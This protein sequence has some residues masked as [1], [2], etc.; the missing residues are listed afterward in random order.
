M[1][2]LPEFCREPKFH[3]N[4]EWIAGHGS[5]EESI[6]DPA[7]GSVVARYRTPA[8]EDIQ[9]TLAAAQRGFH[10]W[11]ATPAV[12]RRRVLREAAALL[13]ARVASIS[14]ILTT[15]QGKPVAEAR[16]EILVT[17]E[18]FEWCAEEAMRVYGRIVPSRDT[19]L[20]QLVMREP[21]GPVAAFS[22]WNFP[23]RNPGFKIAAALGAGCS[24]VVKPAE[25]TPLTC[26]LLA[27]ALAAA[28]LPPGVVNVI[29]GDAPRLSQALIASPV[30]RKI[31]FTGSTRVGQLLAA[32]AAALAKPATMELGGHA[33]AL[34]LDDADIDKAVTQLCRLKYRNAGQTCIS[35]SRFFIQDGVYER[36][37]D[38][39][40]AAARSI[41][42]GD[43]HDESTVM[44]P[45]FHERRI[46]EM[47][48]FVDDAA[49]AH[50]NVR[51]GGA[52]AAGPG[53]FWNPT[54]VADLADNSRL[55]QI[56]P[57]G[58][59]AA[60]SRFSTL[61]EAIERANSLPYGLGAY[62]FTSSLHAAQRISAELESGMIGIN[63]CKLSHVE[64]PFGGVKQSGYGSEGAS[65]GLD[66]Y[67]VT[68]SISIAS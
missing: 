27:E 67:L 15:E 64:T 13:R 30:I 43:G 50:A 45:L 54:V 56:E 19:R 37:V 33:P 26:L 65:E 21:I 58:P 42:I 63:T 61:D 28:G 5:Q 2:A 20:Q 3:I 62:A 9:N 55:M 12:E 24:L 46:P 39:F 16:G 53:Y 41:K 32:Q 35:P 7:T 14:E 68:K 8:A 40:V 6:V 36:F 57:F 52:Q 31:S 60:M 11:R 23:A 51:L 59:I 48:R 66:A 22:A 38:A 47:Q 34:I 17:A 49:A 44:G 25:E 10:R 1:S 4:G 29:Y 18:M